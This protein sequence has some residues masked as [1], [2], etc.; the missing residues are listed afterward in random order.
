MIGTS[1]QRSSGGPV[2]SAPPQAPVAISNIIVESASLSNANVSPGTPVEVNI[3]A[4]N[5]GTADG[6]TVLP[7]YVNGEIES[8]QGV[9][10]QKGQKT[11]ITFT[12]VRDQP[13]T[14]TIYVGG[15]PA[16]SFK[17]ENNLHDL[18]LI[19]GLSMITLSLVLGVIYA[20]RKRWQN[21]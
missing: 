3:V 14:Y 7:L 13:G 6:N 16:G 10:L 15:V 4:T 8:V 20:W 9:T 21:Y 19:I 17:V 18:F 5:R 11:S 12:V 2:Q 1:P